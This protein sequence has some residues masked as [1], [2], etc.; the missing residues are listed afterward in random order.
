M[1]PKLA[2][3]EIIRTGGQREEHEIGKHILLSWIKRMIGAETTDSIN[4][5]DDRGRRTGFVMILD[6]NGY[7]TETITHPTHIEIKPVRARKPVNPEATKIYHAQCKPGTEH[8]IVGDV[9][10]AWDADFA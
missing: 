8:K 3:V 5:R 6:D 2:K 7:D 9:A 4:L 10:I 1:P